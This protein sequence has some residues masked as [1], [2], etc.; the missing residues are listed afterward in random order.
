MCSFW[1]VR[2]YL[3]S[4]QD[5]R[6][7]L[8]S[9]RHR[10]DSYWSAKG[11]VES[12]SFN[13]KIEIKSIV[14]HSKYGSI[15]ILE[16][17]KQNRRKKRFTLL[18][19]FRASSEGGKSL[20]REMHRSNL[21]QWRHHPEK[22]DCDA[23]PIERNAQHLRWSHTTRWESAPRNVSARWIWPWW[24]WSRRWR[25][26]REVDDRKSRRDCELVC[27]VSSLNIDWSTI[28]FG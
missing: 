13:L 3:W 25:T 10:R 2:S 19:Q 28:E 16:I 6:I 14:L 26:R 11:T 23:N 7:R 9:S 24:R 20:D 4:L 1:T 5:D 17:E 27:D 21:R 12:A 8:D 15:T 22:H 18:C